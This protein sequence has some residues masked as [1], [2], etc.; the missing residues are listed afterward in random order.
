MDNFGVPI[1]EEQRQPPPPP[2]ASTSQN[3]TPSGSIVVRLRYLNIWNGLNAVGHEMVVDN[4]GR[5][6]LPK[7]QYKVEGLDPNK[8]YTMHV[9]FDRTNRGLMRFENGVWNQMVEPVKDVPEQTNVI[10]LGTESGADWLRNGVNVNKLRIFNAPYRGV[11]V[12]K[13]VLEQDAVKV[14]EKKVDKINVTP[15]CRYVPVLKI[16]EL[17]GAH[18]IFRHTAKFDEATFVAVKEYKNDKM[19]TMK[20]SRDIYRAMADELAKERRQAVRQSARERG[21]R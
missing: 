21:H 15:R 2:L 9:H 10:A 4:T 14:A 3:I 7:L 16:F 12:S 5:E 18:N 20:L 19:K 1:G 8:M 6:L 13:E 11:K 17:V